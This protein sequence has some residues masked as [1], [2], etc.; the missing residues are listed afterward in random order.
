MP[1]GPSARAHGPREAGPSAAFA[2]REA[3]STTPRPT[4]PTTRRAMANR[5]RRRRC[6]SQLPGS[7]AAAATASG[8]MAQA[9]PGVEGAGSSP[10]LFAA[11]NTCEGEDVAGG[12]W[13]GPRPPPLMEGACSIGRSLDRRSSHRQHPNTPPTRVT[14]RMSA[15]TEARRPPV[16]SGRL[17]RH[18]ASWGPGP[19][20]GSRA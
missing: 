13:E 19:G 8:S 20:A 12:V 11:G 2:G 16:A 3:G 15:P 4:R 10:S 6:S 18:G 17:G 5:C 7:T 9:H 1:C 14:T